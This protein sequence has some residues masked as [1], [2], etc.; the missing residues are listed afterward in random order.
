MIGDKGE[1]IK[2]AVVFFNFI[3][4]FVLSSFARCTFFLF[5]GFI[6]GCA[7]YRI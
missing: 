1:L 6:F 2:L 4:L 7:R 5:I 3:D